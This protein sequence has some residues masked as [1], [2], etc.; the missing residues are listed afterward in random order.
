MVLNSVLKVV[1]ASTSLL[2]RHNKVREGC[3]Y[4]YGFTSAKGIA[5]MMKRHMRLRVLRSS[6]GAQSSFPRSSVVVDSLRTRG[7]L[8]T[9][10]ADLLW[11]ASTPVLRVFGRGSQEQEAYSSTGLTSCLL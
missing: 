9:T 11:T 3:V 8:K 10:R 7:M 4:V 1:S 2:I 5:L 6:S